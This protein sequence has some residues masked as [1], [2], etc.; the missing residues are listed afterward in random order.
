[1]KVA[2][3]RAATLFAVLLSSPFLIVFYIGKALFNENEVFATLSQCL[4]LFPG[5]L[6]SYCRKGFYA[7]TMTHC[8]LECVIGF[9]TLFSQKDTEI[10][11][12]VYIGPQ[13]NIGKSKIEKNC[14]FGSGVHILSGKRQHDFADIE[15]PIQQQGGIFEKIIIGEDT[16]IGNGS[17]VMANI[18]KK[19][20]VGAGSVVIEDVPDYSVVGGNPAR[21]IKTRLL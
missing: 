1:M 5:K 12:G 18:G 19:C 10:E 13:C 2:L 14:L 17:I 21:I 20:I 6:G 8:D 4:S 11:K 9:G 16:W 3:K 7:F 15:I